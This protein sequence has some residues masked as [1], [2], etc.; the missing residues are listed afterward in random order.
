M[1]GHSFHVVG[2]GPDKYDPIADGARI[3]RDVESGKKFSLRDAVTVYANQTV[4]EHTDGAYCG[5][6]A[7]R[8]AA[9]NNGL[10]LAHCHVTPHLIMG[11]KFVI[12]EHSVEDPMLS[13]LMTAKYDY[14]LP[15]EP[16]GW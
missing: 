12:W 8:F 7:V 14:K 13:K 3:Q 1:Q 16:G 6:A 11:K 10:W 5:W 15:G 9:H 2:E 4:G